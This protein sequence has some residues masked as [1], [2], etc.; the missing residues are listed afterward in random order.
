MALEMT[1]TTKEYKEL[2][3]ARVK[4]RKYLIRKKKWNNTTEKMLQELGVNELLQ[5]AG[6]K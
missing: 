3:T 1:A 6:V 5:I 4:A 2:M